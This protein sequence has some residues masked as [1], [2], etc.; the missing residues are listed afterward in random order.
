MYQGYIK[1]AAATP[2][3]TVANCAANAEAIIEE[4][5]KMKEAGAKIMVLPELC[6]TGYT[7]EDL[8]WQETLI[9]NAKEALEQ[10]EARTRDIDAVLFVGL[11]IEHRGKLFNAAAV[12]NRGHVV[13]FVPKKNIPNYNE[14]YE[15]RHFSPG[16]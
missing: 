10:I 13:G 2:K 1:A 14:F 3:V 4:I 11:P 6:I 15:A 12:L 5:R 16:S 7:C 9:K 8:F